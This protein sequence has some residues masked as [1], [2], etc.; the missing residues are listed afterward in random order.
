MP[1][2]NDNDNDND[3]EAEAE[4]NNVGENDD[5]GEDDRD[6]NDGGDGGDDDDAGGG[7]PAHFNVVAHADEAAAGDRPEPQPEG[8]PEI[9]LHLIDQDALWVVKRLHAKG[10]EAYL[11]GGCVRDLLRGRTPKDF[12]VATAA[13]PNQVKAVFR[14]CRLVGRRFRLAHVFFPSGKV[15]ETATFRANP[16]DELEDLPQDLLV[17]RDNVFGNVEQDARRRDLTVNGLFYDPLKGKVIDHVDGRKDLEA[18]LIRTIG[19]PD[20]RFRED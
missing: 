3:N 19:E 12:D 17:E 6:D 8:P 7:V 9:P 18:R 11:T 13:P 5:V 16:I 4:D 1:E 2:N 10:D 14:N 15:I 20:V